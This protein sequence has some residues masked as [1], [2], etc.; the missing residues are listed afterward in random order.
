[1]DAGYRGAIVD[2]YNACAESPEFGIPTN[3]RLIRLHC[4]G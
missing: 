3:G 1:V 2:N 4:V